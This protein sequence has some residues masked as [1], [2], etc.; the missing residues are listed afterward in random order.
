M[1]DKNRLEPLIVD[2]FLDQDNATRIRRP[3]SGNGDV[4]FLLIFTSRRLPELSLFKNYLTRL[5]C[6]DITP[7]TARLFEIALTCDGESFGLSATLFLLVAFRRTVALLGG[8][9]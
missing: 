1:L 8:H 5:N 3:L 4:S 7:T 2:F 9:V 6:S